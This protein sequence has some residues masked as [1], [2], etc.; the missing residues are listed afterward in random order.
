MNAKTKR[1]RERACKSA[2]RKDAERGEAC[3]K[4]TI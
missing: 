3:A 2:A 1:E 4:R